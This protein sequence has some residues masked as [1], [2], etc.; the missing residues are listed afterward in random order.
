MPA[1]PE[2]FQMSD[3]T[4]IAPECSTPHSAPV[5]DLDG[6]RVRYGRRARPEERCNHLNLIYCPSERYV[7]CQDCEEVVD[8]FDAFV[9]LARFHHGMVAESERR[10]EI[11]RQ[12]EAAV[13]VRR[14]A[15]DVDRAWG[16]NL[17]PQCPHCRGALLPEDLLNASVV[18]RE[19]EERRRFRD[20]EGER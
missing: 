9:V 15:K 16:H 7:W 18:S 13:L 10:L 3:K 1:H 19:L 11:A 2:D 8:G 17:A 6:M 12:A 14:A 4:L 5:I 20:R